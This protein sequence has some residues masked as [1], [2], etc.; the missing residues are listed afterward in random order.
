[1]LFRSTYGKNIRVKFFSL[2]NSLKNKVI[3]TLKNPKNLT[4]TARVGVI[5]STCET[6]S[7]SI[8]TFEN[9]FKI[10]GSVKVY[11]INKY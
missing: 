11:G 2:P 10:R 4:S 1:M 3:V 9:Q 7:F 8:Q 6:P 5:T